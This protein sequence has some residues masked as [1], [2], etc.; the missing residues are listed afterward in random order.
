MPPTILLSGGA[1]DAVPLSWTL[2]L[3]R[4]LR[5]ARIPTALYVYPHGTHEWP[6]RQGTVGIERAVAFLRRYL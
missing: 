2:P 5:A 3:Y 4:A 6:G 1:G